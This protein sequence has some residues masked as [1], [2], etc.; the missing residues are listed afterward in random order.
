MEIKKENIM[1]AYKSGN[2]SV[3]EMLRT[4][5]PDIEF[6]AAQGADKRPV[7][8]R[9][10]TFEDA[11]SEL[12]EE[13]PFVKAWNS[14]CGCYE[15]CYGDRDIADLTAYYKLRIIT[16]ALNEGWQP[17]FTEDECRWYPWFWLWT[18]EELEDKDDEW[19]Q[20]YALTEISDYDTEYTDLS[21]AHSNYSPSDRLATCFGS[22]LYLKSKELAKYCGK[23]F[24]DIWADF[25]LIRK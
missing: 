8:E 2:N 6:E 24:I 9:I 10:K 7:T 14:F 22:R 19:K 18:E 17:K 5:F 4:M 16:A 12:G 21:S 23:Q 20:N 1:N 3:K 13:H 15:D 11:C 25:Y